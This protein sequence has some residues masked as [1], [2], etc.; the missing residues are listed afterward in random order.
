MDYY[1]ILGVSRSATQDEI[2]RA[3]RQLALKWHPDHNPNGAEKFKEIAQA[4]E[5]LYDY[6]KRARYNAKLPYKVKN[7]KRK[8]QGPLTAKDFLNDPNLGNC[9]TPKAPLRDIWG[10]RL[11][12]E[13]RR[14]WE[15]DASKEIFSTLS[16][17]KPKPI[18]IKK[19]INK[20][21]EFIDIFSNQYI[22]GDVPNIR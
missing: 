4:F 14:R 16:K 17:P 21:E 3:Y 15:E 9:I 2:V 10:R 13:E 7:V 19:Q 11:S 1:D 12:Q 8:K 18:P 20:K 22:K 5:V 6:D